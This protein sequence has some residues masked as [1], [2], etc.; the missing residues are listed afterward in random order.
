MIKR[1]IIVRT[2]FEGMHSF[3]DAKS[4]VRFLKSMH[5]HV[6]HVE[7][8]I[9]VFHHDRELEFITVKRALDEQL[10]IISQFD[11]SCE[12]YAE[13]IV[14]FIHEKYPI[15]MADQTISRDVSCLVTEDGENGATYSFSK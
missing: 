7:L 14:D 6:F 11:A 8:E 12:K 9:E 2:Q 10:K 4:E 5:R 1:T 13:H 3:A 15:R